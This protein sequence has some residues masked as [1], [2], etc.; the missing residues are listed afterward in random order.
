VAAVLCA[1]GVALWMRRDDGGVA[2]SPDTRPSSAAAARREAAR[3]LRSF[4]LPQGSTVM[5]GKQAPFAGSGWIP[6]DH[7]VTAQRTWDVPAPAQDVHRELQH[8]PQDGMDVGAEGA[9]DDGHHHVLTLDYDVNPDTR[10]PRQV[11]MSIAEVTPTTTRVQVQA[12]ILWAPPRSTRTLIASGASATVHRT[13]D[14]NGRYGAITRTAD[15]DQARRLAADVDALELDLVPHGC[16][17]DG[18][19]EILTFVRGTS[20][21]E[22]SVNG[23]CSTVSMVLN[24]KNVG[25][26][27]LTAALSADIDAV[28]TS[29]G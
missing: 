29:S 10:S 23:P 19:Q 4:G 7:L 8:R 15:A 12:Q 24:R 25:A 20:T 9:S 22:L 11:A 2:T 1:A 6:S 16:V 21:W 28:L 17:G 13:A 3:V 14:L 26:F 5:N 18:T 27:R